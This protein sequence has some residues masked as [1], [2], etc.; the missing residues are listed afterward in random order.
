MD[1]NELISGILNV[2]A[3]IAMI[4]TGMLAPV[5]IFS[6]FF[7]DIPAAVQGYIEL[8]NGT[9]QILNSTDIFNMIAERILVIIISVTIFIV[10]IKHITDNPDIT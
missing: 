7:K 5:A 9:R 10:S 4:I 6:L 3:H 8:E 2:I 1:A